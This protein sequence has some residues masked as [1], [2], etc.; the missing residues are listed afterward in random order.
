MGN[1]VHSKKSQECFF[2]FFHVRGFPY[3]EIQ[4]FL[5]MNENGPN[6]GSFWEELRSAHIRLS[7]AN[8]RAGEKPNT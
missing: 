1:P 3:I 7:K 2:D 6:L 5:R 4:S 8:R